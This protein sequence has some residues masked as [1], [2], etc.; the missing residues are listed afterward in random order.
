MEFQRADWLISSTHVYL[1]SQGPSGP[2]WLDDHL[3]SAECFSLV[4]QPPDLSDLIC[5]VIFGVDQ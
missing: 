5:H 1:P 4:V 3:N 2:S